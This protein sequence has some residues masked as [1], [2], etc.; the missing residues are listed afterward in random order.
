MKSEIKIRQLAPTLT[1]TTSQQS[2]MDTLFQSMKEFPEQNDPHN[3]DS[4]LCETTEFP[5][6]ENSAFQVYCVLIKRNRQTS[7]PNFSPLV[8]QRREVVSMVLEKNFEDCDLEAEF[9]T[10]L[11]YVQEEN[12]TSMGKYRIIFH[13]EKRKTI[14]HTLF[15]KK[16]QSIIT[17]IQIE[18]EPTA[19]TQPTEHSTDSREVVH[20]D[21]VAQS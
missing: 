13:K 3:Q 18:V 21:A 16:A 17:E 15:K 7:Y 1:L 2:T 6:R 4:F 5:F 20:S 19:S 11:H 8:L 10:L 12:L 9:S 14:R